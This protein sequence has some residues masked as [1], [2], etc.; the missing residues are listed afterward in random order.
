MKWFENRPLFGKKIVV[1]KDN[2]NLIK[3]IL[4]IMQDGGY[5][6]G[7]EETQDSKGN[8]L[9]I[10]LIGAVNNC[11]VIKPRFQIGLDQFERFEKRYLPAFGFG[12][13]IVSTNKGIMTHEQA[14]K[15][16][17]GGKLNGRIQDKTKHS[18]QINWET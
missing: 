11:G 9:S 2:S 4:Q 6:G 3:G 10:N 14:I 5:I 13:L 17:L 18:P 16:N 8:V 1:T 7:Y 15:K 12:F